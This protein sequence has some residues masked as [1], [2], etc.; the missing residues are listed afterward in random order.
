MARVSTR[1][2][3]DGYTNLWGSTRV[4]KYDPRPESYG[5][6]DEASSVLGLA[7]ALAS[8]RRVKDEVYQIQQELYLMM[9]ELATPPEDYDRSRYK[10][11]ASHVAR[12]DALLEDLKAQTEV[13]R[14]FIIPGETAAGAALDV[15]RTVI[16]RA[17]RL[18]ARL[19]HEGVIAN[20]E[21]LH[22]VNR[23]SD[24]VFVLARYEE[25]R[26]PEGGSSG[27]S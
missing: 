22:Y 20:P 24:V 26:S 2:G 15:A 21:V 6:L 7:R 23:L 16:R 19:L 3:D 13:Q 12:L 17:E 11:D 10:V 4:P 9:A 18:I 1:R 5:T 8:Q 14:R 27:T 25:E